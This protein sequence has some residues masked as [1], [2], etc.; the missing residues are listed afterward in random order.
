MSQK[1]QEKG[2]SENHTDVS[3]GDLNISGDRDTTHDHNNAPRHV[4]EGKEKHYLRF[5]SWDC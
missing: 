5:L 3:G 4:F 2:L 1:K